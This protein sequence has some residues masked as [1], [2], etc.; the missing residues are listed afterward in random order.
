MATLGP[1]PLSNG[2]E[3]HPKR[4]RTSPSPP[5]LPSSQ[6]GRDFLNDCLADDDEETIGMET[7]SHPVVA[8]K[9]PSPEDPST[10]SQPARECWKRPPPPKLDPSSDPLVF[11]Q[12][13]IDYYV[14]AS[15]VPGMPG[16]GTGPVPVLRMFGVT[17]DGNSVCSHIHGFLPYFFVPAPREFST[18]HCATFRRA[19]NTA[20]MDD[21]RSSRDNI[22]EA[23]P[24]VEMC[25]KS[26]IYGFYFNEMSD[27]LRVTVSLPKLVAPARRLVSCI[28]VPP[29]GQID[30]QVF[31]A[32][33]DFEVRFMVDTGVVGCSWIELPAG[34]Y[35]FRNQSQTCGTGT[36]I[37]GDGASEMK[38]H[39]PVTRCQI[40]VDVSYEDFISHPTRGGVAGN[41][42]CEDPEF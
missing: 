4:Q 12:I 21:L 19:L 6:D 28:S 33:I 14:G 32:N 13:D 7:T 34:K 11:Q 22:R 18:Q 39:P 8:T 2:L 40:E 31:E 41:S 10:S 29:F 1:R 35:R 30:Y 36:I 9:T 37:G 3:P 15:T 17:S 25:R 5:P 16:M 24:A 20:V 38:P 23:V 26:S 42:S 27:F